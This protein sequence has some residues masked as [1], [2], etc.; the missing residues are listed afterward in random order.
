[1]AFMLRIPA[2]KTSRVNASRYFCFFKY[3]VKEKELRKTVF[4]QIAV[5]NEFRDDAPRGFI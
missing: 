4:M 5:R 1:M 3:Q 2:T